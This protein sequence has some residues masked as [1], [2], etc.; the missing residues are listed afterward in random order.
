[1]KSDHFQIVRFQK[2]QSLKRLAELDD[3]NIK[4]DRGESLLQA[5][6]AYKNRPAALELIRRGIDVNSQDSKGLTA[7]HYA[8]AWNDAETARAILEAGG[9]LSIVTGLGKTPVLD[10]VFNSKGRDYA[11]LEAM[12]DHGAIRFVDVPDVYGNSARSFAERLGYPGALELM[13]RHE[14]RAKP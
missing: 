4:N 11:V 13:A 2:E 7:L 6:I 10:A 5:A 1:M 3:V 12:M 8:A 14:G 9:D